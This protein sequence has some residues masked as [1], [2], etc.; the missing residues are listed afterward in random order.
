MEILRVDGRDNAIFER[1]FRLREEVRQAEQEFP[2]GF[3]REDAQVMF[4]TEH[5]DVRVEGLGLVD[6]DSWLGMAWLDWW[7]EENT[8]VLDVEIVVAPQYRRQGVA[9]KLLDVIVD[10]ARADGRTRLSTNVIAGAADG[11]SSGTAFAEARGFVRT[12]EELHQVLRLPLSDEAIGKLDRPVTG[13]ELVQWR[14]HTPDEWLAEFADAHR[15]MSNDVPQGERG[16]EE[17]RW[18]PERIR[19]AEARRIAQGRFCHTTVAVDGDGR[20]AAYTQLGG[21]TANRERL[22]Q[23]DTFV[24]PEHRGHRLGMA[25]KI[26]NLRSLQADLTEPAIVHT[27]NAPENGPM[28]RVN[29]HLGFTPSDRRVALQR[30][31]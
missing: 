29:E 8:D 18:T 13:Y 10:K 17:M 28:I 2:A 25:V 6:G 30:T 26:P 20:L 24:R 21:S 11:T 22:Y 5:S 23:Y 14:E 15:A 9:S 4:A 3:S 7:L 19:E 12:H 31:L 1:Y 27:W 16:L